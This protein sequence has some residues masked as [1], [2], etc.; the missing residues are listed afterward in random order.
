MSTAAKKLE[1]AVAGTPPTPASS[2][3]VSHLRFSS[4]VSFVH[5]F[6]GSFLLSSSVVFVLLWKSK[7]LF[8]VSHL[9]ATLVHRAKVITVSAVSC[10]VKQ[11]RVFLLPHPGGLLFHRRV[12]HRSISLVAIILYTCLRKTV[13]QICKLKMWSLVTTTL[14]QNLIFAQLNTLEIST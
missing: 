6:V 1:L 13:S 4:T 11:M 2:T 14:P 5:E 7:I 12:T 8:R 10:S 9:Q 3:S